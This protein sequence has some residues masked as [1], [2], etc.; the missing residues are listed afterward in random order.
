MRHATII[1]LLLGLLACSVPDGNPEHRKVRL[2]ADTGEEGYGESFSEERY[3]KFDDWRWE[4]EGLPDAVRFEMDR[5]TR[6]R[7]YVVMEYWIRV[8]EWAPPGTYRFRAR[9][10]LSYLLFPEEDIELQFVLRVREGFDG[11]RSLQVRHEIPDESG[12]VPVS[13]DTGG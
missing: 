2:V 4:A 11:G 1:P 9:V 12:V 10:T 3:E 13:I 7:R 5:V 8:A 6:H